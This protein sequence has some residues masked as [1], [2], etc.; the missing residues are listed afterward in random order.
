MIKSVISKFHK[1]GKNIM[2]IL[3]LLLITFFLLGM[4]KSDD[5]LNA[6]IT[7]V[8]DITGE[9]NLDNLSS[10]FNKVADVLK[11]NPESVNFNRPHGKGNP[12]MLG[13]RVISPEA[14]AAKQQ[15]R[16][17]A[18]A[19]DWLQGVLHPTSIPS[20]AAIKANA[21]RIDKLA[22][23]EKEGKW[24]KAMQ[25]VNPDEMYEIIKAVGSA[26]YKTGIEARKVKIERVIK[27]MQPLVASVAA[28][29]DAMP[30][31]TDADREKRLIAGRRL[32]IEVGKKLRGI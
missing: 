29:I 4:V 16:A 25:K 18:A 23:S 19:D 9:V 30:Q 20:E 32:M 28:T 3:G 14:W 15:S 8:K 11:N 1:G 21:K 13:S 12:V 7:E 26:G 31:A 27:E 2:E 5:P 22:Q 17:V 10:S 6:G 24:L